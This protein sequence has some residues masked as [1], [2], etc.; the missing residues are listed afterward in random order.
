MSNNPTHLAAIDG[1][2]ALQVQEDKLNLGQNAFSAEATSYAKA[3]GGKPPNQFDNTNNVTFTEV[4][5][6]A[7]VRPIRLL[8]VEGTGS[9]NLAND[10]ELAFDSQVYIGGAVKR[11]IGYHQK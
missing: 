4:D 7:A 6:G 8:V 9:A 5:I 11:V 1:D 2:A 3:E 10:Q